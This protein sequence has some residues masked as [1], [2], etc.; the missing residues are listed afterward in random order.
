[1]D[2]LRSKLS[3]KLKGNAGE[4]I[5]EVLIAL[6]IAALAL[7]MLA[8]VITTTVKMVNENKRKMNDY[9]MANEWITMHRPLNGDYG[10]TWTVTVEDASNATVNL[11]NSDSMIEV[12]YYVN[13]VVG[14][15]KEDG[16]FDGIPVIAFWR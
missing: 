7:T 11:T 13:S 9:Y 5:A 3:K 14:E 6:L 2:R 4:T 12:H 1:M 10:K 8:S 15:N 16:T